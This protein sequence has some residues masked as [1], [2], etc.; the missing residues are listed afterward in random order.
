MA[1]VESFFSDTLAAPFD[2]AAFEL[3][4]QWLVRTQVVYQDDQ[5]YTGWAAS[6]DIVKGQTAKAM[7]EEMIRI[8]FSLLNE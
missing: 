1:R 7:I 2:L 5:G 6:A 8:S 3:A 4:S